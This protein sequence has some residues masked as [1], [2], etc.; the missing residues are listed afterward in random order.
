MFIE[1]AGNC[2]FKRASTWGYEKKKP[3]LWQTKSV[4]RE[5]Q[6]ALRP[7]PGIVN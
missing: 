6:G 7:V 1:M 3:K 5:G 2:E 4:E